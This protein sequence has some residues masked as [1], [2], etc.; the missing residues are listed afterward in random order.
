[1]LTGLVLSLA[2]FFFFFFNFL[3]QW[4]LN[5]CD[6]TVWL[7]KPKIVTV[8]LLAEKYWYTLLHSTKS[9]EPTIKQPC[10][11]TKFFIG[12]VILFQDLYSVV[13]VPEW[14]PLGRHQPLSL[15]F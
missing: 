12:D 1:M 3:L 11:E 7:A 10:L 9:L 8:W 14:D 13:S 5:S 15:L 6:E 2:A 4:Q